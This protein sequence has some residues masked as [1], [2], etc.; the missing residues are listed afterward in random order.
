LRLTVYTDYS[1]RVLMYL[2]VH[3]EPLPTIAE[4]AGSYGVSR[5]HLMKVV[6]E[7]G[8]AGYIETVRGKKGGLRLGRPAAEIGLGE[9]VRKTEPD[10]ALV[11][12]FE[13]AKTACVLTPSCKLRSALYQAQAAFLEVLDRYTLADLVTHQTILAGLLTR[14]GETA[15]LGAEQTQD[16]RPRERRSR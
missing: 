1:L 3:S 16:A 14:E 4:I 15:S 2:A 10:L 8:L 7:L 13:S 6:Y 5:A 12:C 11:P 9:V